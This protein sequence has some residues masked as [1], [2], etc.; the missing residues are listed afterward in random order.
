MSAY[1]LQDIITSVANVLQQQHQQQP[2][3]GHKKLTILTSTDASEWR[4]WRANFLVIA[5]IN[6]WDEVCQRRETPT[7]MEEDAK[8]NTMGIDY[9]AAGTGKDCIDT[10]EA[11]VVT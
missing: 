7:V 3:G 5:Q 10:Y 1:Q 2:S 4:T 8:K 6:G 9:E 11:H